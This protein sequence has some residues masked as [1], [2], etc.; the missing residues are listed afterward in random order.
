MQRPGYE[1]LD[2][3]RALSQALDDIAAPSDVERVR[4]AVGDF[5]RVLEDDER[6][7]ILEQL[8]DRTRRR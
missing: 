4:R 1:F 3:L 2:A 6:P 7:Q 8:I 5:A